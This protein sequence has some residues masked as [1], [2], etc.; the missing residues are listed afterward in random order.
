MTILAKMIYIHALN[1]TSNHLS[2]SERILFYNNIE[3]IKST[4]GWQSL[5]DG[6]K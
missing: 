1:L 6:K 4:E 5:I 2:L 3:Y